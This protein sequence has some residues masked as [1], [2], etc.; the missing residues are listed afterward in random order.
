MTLKILSKVWNIYRHK[1]KQANLICQ[2]KISKPNIYNK[3]GLLPG[4]KNLEYSSQ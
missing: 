1:Y 4:N 3:I 2:Y